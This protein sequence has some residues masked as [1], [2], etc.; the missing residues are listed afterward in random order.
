MAVVVRSL[1]EG[2]PFWQLPPSHRVELLKLKDPERI[3][4]VAQ[5]ALDR[6]MT[7]RKLREV[8]K[9]QARRT[10]STRGR[11]PLPE[12]LK[13]LRRCVKLMRD[14]ETGRLGFRRSDIDE[15]DEEQ[16]KEAAELAENL[17]RRAGELAKLLGVE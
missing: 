16:G 13:A 15:L 6:G 14:E 9:K 8:A 2:T 3:E 1:P 12:V 5:K 11:K 17:H 4:T 10:R 7:V